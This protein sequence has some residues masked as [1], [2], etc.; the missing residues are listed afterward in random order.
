MVKGEL[1]RY[2]KDEVRGDGVCGVYVSLIDEISQLNPPAARL[3][4]DKLL[5]A[6]LRVVELGSKQRRVRREWVGRSL[7]E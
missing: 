4:R 6:L 5:A 7:V 3:A 2:L 1:A